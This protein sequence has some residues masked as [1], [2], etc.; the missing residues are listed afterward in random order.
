MASGGGGRILAGG[1]ESSSGPGAGGSARNSVGETPVF[2]PS[3][4]PPWAL[5]PR[6]GLGDPSPAASG[7]ASWNRVGLPSRVIRCAGSVL[8]AVFDVN[9]AG[10]AGRA[11][12]SRA[13]IRWTANATRRRWRTRVGAGP[14][15]RQS[16][17][18]PVGRWLGSASSPRRDACRPSPPRPSGKRSARRPH[19]SLH[20]TTST[21]RRRPASTGRWPTSKR[22]IPK[23]P[24]ATTPSSSR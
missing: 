15:G 19:P 24:A 5:L 11:S 2:P 16:S 23:P 21:M 20:R 18:W 8:A 22:R 12:P 10:A 3:A 4:A 6:Q 13:R 17:A 1:A 7:L 9:T 14:S